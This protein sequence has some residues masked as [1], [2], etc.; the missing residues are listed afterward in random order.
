MGTRG[1]GSQSRPG[2]LCTR[3]H[4]KQLAGP[5]RRG[6]EADEC[7]YKGRGCRDAGR[8][9]AM[10]RADHALIFGGTP[11]GAQAGEAPA[12]GNGWHNRQFWGQGPNPEINCDRKEV[13]AC[14]FRGAD[15]GGGEGDRRQTE[16]YRAKRRVEIK[17]GGNEGF[18]EKRFHG[19]RF[20]KSKVEGAGAFLFHS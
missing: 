14:R 6:K 4:G 15:R 1:P 8:E 13:G 11:K 9:A 12:W 2:G 10:T 16:N 7:K 18:G 17:K 3:R 19:H 5:A 20:C